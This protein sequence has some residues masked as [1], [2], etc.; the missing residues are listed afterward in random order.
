MNGELR[1]YGSCAEMIWSPQ[2]LLC[3]MAADVPLKE[4]DLIF[5]GTPEGVSKINTGDIVHA[6]ILNKI[7]LNF[8]II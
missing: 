8:T 1:Q 7:D 2:E 6:S 3:E 5:T 4:G